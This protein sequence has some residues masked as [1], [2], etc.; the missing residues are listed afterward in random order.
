[1]NLIDNIRLVHTTEM[2]VERIRKNLDLDVAVV[3]DVVD[4]CKSRILENPDSIITKGKNWYVTF[5]DCVLTVN[6]HSFTIITAHRKP[7]RQSA[8]I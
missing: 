6:S 5:D 2:G 7:V 4:W 1:M 8:P 3:A